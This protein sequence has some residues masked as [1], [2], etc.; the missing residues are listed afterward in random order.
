MQVHTELIFSQCVI[1]I[2]IILCEFV[3]L[4]CP[5]QFYASRTNAYFEELVKRERDEPRS[6]EDKEELIHLREELKEKE[7]TIRDLRVSVVVGLETYAAY[8]L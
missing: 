5:V 3:L 6:E 7:N 4:L 2:Y 8:V 1:C